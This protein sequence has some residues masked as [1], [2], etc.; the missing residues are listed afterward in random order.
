MSV[1]LSNHENLVEM[2]NFLLFLYNWYK[3]SACF[4]FLNSK[5]FFDHAWEV[6][7]ASLELYYNKT[8][9]DIQQFY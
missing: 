5:S 3:H 8:S 2:P 9:I 1:I 6:W 4:R 7:E